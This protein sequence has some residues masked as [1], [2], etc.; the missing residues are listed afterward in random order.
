MSRMYDWHSFLQAADEWFIIYSLPPPLR[1]VKLFAIGHTV[2]LY[3]KAANTKITDDIKGA[4]NFR[5]NLKAIWDDCKAKDSAFMPQYEIRDDIY[6]RDLLPSP[7]EGLNEEETLHFGNNY[8][9]YIIVKYLPHLKYLGAPPTKMKTE[10]GLYF[11]YHN[12]YWIDFLKEMR[13]YLGHPREGRRDIISFHI[14]HS[15]MAPE[16][17]RFLK[18]LY[19]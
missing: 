12:R 16:A 3:L 6:N 17:V 14:D 11:Q 18:M 13:R 7:F 4:M 10:G 15:S 9:L 19:T 2:E 1:H 5:H 8:E